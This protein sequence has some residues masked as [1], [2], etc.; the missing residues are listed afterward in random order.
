[1]SSRGV[2]G[3]PSRCSS[4]SPTRAGPAPQ[5][6][7]EVRRLKWWIVIPVALAVASVLHYGFGWEFCDGGRRCPHRYKTWTAHQ[8][9]RAAHL[10]PDPRGLAGHYVFHGCRVP[11]L[12][13]TKSDVDAYEESGSPSPGT[14][15]ARPASRSRG[16]VRRA[17][18]ASATGTTPSASSTSCAPGTSAPPPPYRAPRVGDRMPPAPRAGP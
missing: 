18:I 6:V 2:T 14:P 16:G 1:M 11:V 9:V 13:G 8:I 5:A 7:G 17:G 4:L 12:M 15:T 3:D 10:Q